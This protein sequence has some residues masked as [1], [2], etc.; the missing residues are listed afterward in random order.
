MVEFNDGIM[1]VPTS[2]LRKDDTKCMYPPYDSK[3]VNDAIKKN[4]ESKDDWQELDILKIFAR[5]SKFTK[6]HK[7]LV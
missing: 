7:A 4:E 5:A 6:I 2:W 1:A 3:N